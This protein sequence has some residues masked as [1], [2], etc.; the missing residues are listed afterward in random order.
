MTLPAHSQDTG[1]PVMLDR[2]RLLT[3]A[4]LGAATLAGGLGTSAWSPATAAAGAPQ[5]PGH[6]PGRIYLGA[7]AS[8]DLTKTTRHTG[9]LGLCRSFHDWSD[10]RNE[11]KRIRA[12]HAEHRLPWA[13]FSPPVKARGIWR[14]VASGRFDNDI[15]ARARLYASLKGPVVSTF[16]HEPQNDDFGSPSDFV[17]AWVRIHDV[18]K[19]ETGL[20]NCA[21]API[22]GDWVFN[23]VNRRDAPEE[24]VVPAIMSRMAFLGI[25]LY[26]N[27]SGE[28]YDVRLGRILSYLD[29]AGY[30][31]MTVGIGET[32]CTDDYR[33]PTGAQWWKSSWDWAAAHADRIAA[34]AYFNS[35]GNNNSGNTWLLT[36]SK[37]K[38]SAFRKSLASPVACTL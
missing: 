27:Q 26:Q 24:F 1:R 6:K 35:Q 36:Q 9:A 13:S 20:K 3:M 22:I 7:A 30:P 31:R 21:F 23:P 14:Q 11:E 2:R 19:A 29:R 10:L 4:G 37:S 38:L 25:D 18:M 28:G 34:I 17:A 32:G 12:D 16:N 15:K 8:G 5:W 33:S